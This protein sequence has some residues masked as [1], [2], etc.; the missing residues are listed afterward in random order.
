MQLSFNQ[1]RWRTVEMYLEA[2]S[3]H[4]MKVKQGVE[5]EVINSFANIWNEREIISNF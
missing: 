4:Y 2:F 1:A 5:Y 3:S